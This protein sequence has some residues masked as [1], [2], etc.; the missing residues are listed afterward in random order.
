M[1]EAIAQLIEGRELSSEQAT[2][3]MNQMMDGM[4]TPAQMGAFLV[5]LRVK[6]ETVG[7]IQA[8]ARVMRARCIPV[9]HEF[10]VVLDTCGTGGDG[11]HTFNISTVSAFVAAAAGVPVAKH[12]NRAVSSLSGSA[13]VLKALGVNID[14]PPEKVERCF[15]SAGIAFLFAPFFHPSMKAVGPVRRE[16]GLRTVFNI[17]GPLTNPA[18]ANAQVLGVFRGDLCPL[19]AGVLAGL[20]VRRA[21]VVYGQDGLDEVSLCA[22]TRVCEVR[23]GRV[24]DYEVRGSD[25]GFD[26]IRSEDLRGEEPGGNAAIA[27]EVLGNRPSV[28]LEAVVLNSA[29]A[30]AAAERVETVSEGVA[31]A[32]EVLAS[33]QAMRKFEQ[34][35]KATHDLA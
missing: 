33:G 10:P 3:C 8:F 20:D 21:F 23:D 11:R 2:R 17:L 29:F 28:R 24:R 32:R 5:A 14:L 31:L 19:L 15:H 9:R 30:L 12:G 22:P 7:E 4:A 6:G 25:F 27:L 1:Q 18:G 34:F 35:R 16:L 26:T 13:D